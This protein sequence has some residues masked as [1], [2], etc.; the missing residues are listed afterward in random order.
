MLPIAHVLPQ[1]I[2]TVLR[3][4][5]CVLSAE[6]GAGKTTAV[7]LALLEAGVISGRIIMLEPRRLACVR[8]A[9]YMAGQ[10]GEDVGQTVGYRVR[11]DSRVS[12]TTRIEVVTEGILTRM[13]Q[14]DPELEGIELLIFDEFHERSLHADLGLAL[15]C[16]CQAI[17]RN[18]LKL[19]VMSATLDTG[20]ISALLDHA[21][22]IESS[23]R[24]YPVGIS[25]L[26]KPE[27]RA[28][29][30]AVVRAC[31][32]ALNE[33]AGDVL[34]FLPGIKEIRRSSEALTDSGLAEQCRVHWLYGEAS[35]AEQ[36]AAL[37][38]DPQ[39]RKIILATSIA[40]TSLTIDGV[41][42]VVDVGL[43]RRVRFDPRRGM[44]GLITQT[45]SA[46][47]AT[48]RA[49]RAG[50]QQPGHCY[51][52]WR[53]SDSLPAFPEPEICQS[54]LMPLALELAQWGNRPEDMRF[55]TPPPSA[56]LRQAQDFLRHIGAL[57]AT[58]TL[59]EHGRALHT[60]PV[61]PRLA[62]MLISARQANLGALACELAAMLEERD[63]LR[64]ERQTDIQLRWQALREGRGDKSAIQRARQQTKRLQQQL[65]ISDQTADSAL[66]GSVLA[67][68]YPDR[69]GKSRTRDSGR[70]QLASG[71]G[72]QLPPGDPLAVHTLIACADIDAEGVDTTI[73]QAAALDLESTRQLL[74]SLFNTVEVCEFD[75]TSR[76]LQARRIER[77]GLLTLSSTPMPLPTGDLSH[78]WLVACQRLS[79]AQ[80][81]LPDHCRQWLM[82]ARWLRQQQDCHHWPMLD[83]EALNHALPDWLGAYLAGVRTWDDLVAL[84][85]QN[86]LSHYLPDGAAAEIE[87]LAPASLCAATGTRVMLD[88]SAEVPVMA[89]RIQEMFGV[90]T[91][92][93]LV[94]GTVAVSVHLLSPARRP[95]A[96]TRDLASFW[97]NAYSAVRKD[98]R[99]QYPKHYWPENPWLAEATSRS[100]AADD[101]ARKR[102]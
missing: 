84:P 22:V 89:V 43:V 63:L 39:R 46:A 15:A 51:R 49:G 62:H 35:L 79:L 21:P 53:E 67:L 78:H 74:P 93:T 23:G 68:A 9:H 91:T 29:P 47:T 100:K 90:E 80:L 81:P 86:A 33:Q 30:Q 71:I 26:G 65:G 60:L 66:L 37:A 72:A 41:T 11:G 87:R 31:R 18:N 55:L 56:H 45:V 5:C 61:H 25:Y 92:P 6:P 1:L 50:R 82:R 10:L 73:R 57:S 96:V 77:L 58:R 59:T 98:M 75:T 2:D 52:L 17:Y 48:Q 83:D 7:P 85:W 102:Q 24:S 70:Y 34:V 27:L 4:P 8:A 28:L 88:Y 20:A 38:P 64:G 14:Q 13:I 3:A 97:R 40:E 32:Q 99:G 12:P 101:R 19:L 54:D 44:Q 36:Q 69:I 16:D 76:K 95:I 42:S 94:D